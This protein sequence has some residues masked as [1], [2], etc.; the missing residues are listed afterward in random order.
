MSIIERCWS[1][2]VERCSMYRAMSADPN[3]ALQA[4]ECEEGKVI[5]R[6]PAPPSLLP[7]S[8]SHPCPYNWKELFRH[9][10]IL[11]EN[12]GNLVSSEQRKTKSKLEK[13]TQVKQNCSFLAT[14]LPTAIRRPRKVSL[15][16]SPLF[17]A[18]R[19]ST[20]LCCLSFSL[21]R[22]ARR[23][24]W[25]FS[26]MFGGQLEGGWLWQERGILRL[27]VGNLAHV[28][29]IRRWTMSRTAK[30]PETDPTSPCCNNFR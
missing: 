17:T 4:S 2:K 7:V 21:R 11:E 14:P 8:G 26:D 30:Y 22:W 27:L 29:S 3:R 9:F 15:P 23:P 19:A 12:L 13:E 25:A 20:N 5:Q 28:S 6:T 16:A 10:S 24:H 18:L 1:I